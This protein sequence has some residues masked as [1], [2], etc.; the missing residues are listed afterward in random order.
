MLQDIQLKGST[1][2]LQKA[3]NYFQR[4]N[5]SRAY[6]EAVKGYELDPQLPELFEIYRDTRDEI[7]KKLQV[8]IAI[9]AFGAPDGKPDLGPQFS[10][11]LISYLFRTL[12]YGINIVER[13]KIDLLMKEHKREFEVL[14]D[15]LNVNMIVTG[16]VSLMNIDKQ[17]AQ[18]VTTVRVQTGEKKEA[19]PEYDLILKTH[20]NLEKVTLP[21][22]V[23]TIPLYETYNYTHGKTTIK[24]FATVSVRIFDVQQGS[25]I[26]AQEFNANYEKSDTYQDAVAPANIQ[27][28]LLELPTDTEV[29]E[30]LRNSIIEQLA[31][32]IQQHFEKREGSFLK[33][34]QYFLVRK[35]VPKA[36]DALAAGFL[37]CTKAGIGKES[38]AFQTIRDLIIEHTEGG[39]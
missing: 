32:V 29:M 2:Y 7:L 25:I 1:F 6:L 15:I 4:G 26:Y 37:Y 5:V 3:Q 13:E 24:G 27:G 21:N 12:P 23:I 28:D 39:S 33:D 22:P 10:D 8:Y 36:I 20:K 14:G 19:N 9:S 31:A 35:E 17:N 34:A 11:A 16:N 30:N 18:N 38:S